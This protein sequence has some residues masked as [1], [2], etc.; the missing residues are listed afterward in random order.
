M[1][2]GPEMVAINFNFNYFEGR[3]LSSSI[4]LNNVDLHV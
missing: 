2:A 1:E 4:Y 3:S